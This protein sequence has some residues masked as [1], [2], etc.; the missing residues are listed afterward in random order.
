MALYS[1]LAVTASVVRL[2]V[3]MARMSLVLP[4]V[5]YAEA[6]VRTHAEEHGGT[7]STT[8]EVSH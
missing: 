2:T 5:P 4:A 6:A 3:C 1:R 7:L 8:S